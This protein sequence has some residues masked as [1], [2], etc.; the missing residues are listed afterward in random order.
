MLANSIKGGAVIAIGKKIAMALTAVI[1]PLPG[2]AGAI[3]GAGSFWPTLFGAAN[4]AAV[5]ASQGNVTA[6]PAATSGAL[7]LATFIT[8]GLAAV[9]AAALVLIPILGGVKM[10][11][12]KKVGM[13]A[14]AMAGMIIPI[15][16][17]AYAATVANATDP[18]TATAGMTKI[19][20]IMGGL[21]IVGVVL[22]GLLKAVGKVEISTM[23]GFLAVM[24]GM[25]L[26]AIP[27]YMAAVAIGVIAT[28]TAGISEGALLIGLLSLAVVMGAVGY[29]GVKIV[30]LLG[31]VKPDQAKTA[32]LLMFPLAA[33][34]A[35]VG[36]VLMPALILAGI[37]AVSGFGLGAMALLA[38][39]ATLAMVV[40]NITDPDTGIIAAITRLAKVP[41]ANPEGVANIVKAV[42]SLVKAAAAMMV[43][44]SKIINQADD[45]ADDTTE[46][47]ALFKNINST[48]DALMKNGIVAIIDKLIAL[49]KSKDIGENAD[50][51]MGAIANAIKAAASFMQA[52]QFPDSFYAMM[53]EIDDDEEI[54]NILCSIRGIMGVMIDQLTGENG[55]VNMLLK[56]LLSGDFMAALN[57]MP[58]PDKIA[59]FVNSIA[60]LI[61]AVT[62][63][64]GAIGMDKN[65]ADVLN[66][67][68]K[69]DND[70]TVGALKE[71]RLMME[72]NIKAMGGV[73]KQMFEGIGD[74]IGKLDPIFKTLDKTKASAD[75]LAAGAQLMGAVLNPISSLVTG[76]MP[77]ILKFAETTNKGAEDAPQED[78]AKKMTDSMNKLKTFIENVILSINKLDLKNL[79]GGITKAISDS[80]LGPKRMEAAT[81]MLA[82]IMNMITSVVSTTTQLATDMVKAK[83]KP[84]SNAATDKAKEV[85][86]AGE[87]SKGIIGAIG[88]M[89]EK[90]DLG[91]VIK[92]VVAQ[93]KKNR[94]NKSTI[95]SVKAL[96]S[97][98]NGLMKMMS[99]MTQIMGSTEADL[100]KDP[101]YRRMSKDHDYSMD[102]ALRQAGAGEDYTTSEQNAMDHARLMA[103]RRTELIE[104]KIPELIKMMEQTIDQLNTKKILPRIVAL[105]GKIPPLPKR[106][107]ERAKNMVSLI[108]SLSGMVAAMG[109][110]NFDSATEKPPGGGGGPAILDSF[111]QDLIDLETKVLKKDNVD[112]MVK[113]AFKLRRVGGVNIRKKNVENANRVLSH[114]QHFSQVIPSLQGGTMD[115]GKV[116]ENLEKLADAIS[117]SANKLERL[118]GIGGKAGSNLVQIA[119]ALT[120]AGGKLKIQHEDIVFNLDV[121]VVIDAERMEKKLGKTKA[122]GK[123]GK[124][125]PSDT[126]KP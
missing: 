90:I 60:G 3:G 68:T 109:S 67:L 106:M 108:S 87:S 73:L 58:N 119:T 31:S 22:V 124:A 72:N 83:V 52:V 69:D 24:V 57:K 100:M 15:I 49:A 110:D 85:A 104:R 126:K 103:K 45:F 56:K 116:A 82:P 64:M 36:A 7:K 80:G 11:S 29:L 38:G 51:A 27:V 84:P 65:T 9:G 50:K 18:A 117:H 76:A 48:V 94:M 34:L 21:G 39:L 79:M 40:K 125:Q 99:T 66:K 6:T 30:E 54:A 61:K 12:I 111:S 107:V 98:M 88:D 5:P 113:I 23:L 46:M 118:K 59:Q 14:L 74:M 71:V 102:R 26:A 44:L 93:L 70:E 114:M 17:I 8:V 63:I 105:M 32:G 41:I 2:G 95:A 120:T 16:G 10:S 92:K 112:K 35:V 25:T 123:S 75:K 19:A 47:D 62:G 96:V 97:F 28:S 115:I 1:R 89:I 121:N 42:S 4:S 37:I 91:P 13:F 78:A 55:V 20:M 33:M 81:K 43:G 122:R 86:A 77:V 53:E 101:D